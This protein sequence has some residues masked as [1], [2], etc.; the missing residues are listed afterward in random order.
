M[1]DWRL[2]GF[3]DRAHDGL[4]RHGTQQAASPAGL[5][6]SL[7]LKTAVTGVELLIDR[8]QLW[9]QSAARHVSLA[10]HL[11]ALLAL[12]RRWRRLELASWQMLLA[13]VQSK[14][15]AGESR[16]CSVCCRFQ[17]CALRSLLLCMLH[18]KQIS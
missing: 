9:E 14:H 2:G 7:P 5:A 6:V 12:A 15:A 16:I 11:E 17:L 10:Q 1:G 3:P 13:R 8:A 4:Q 18:M